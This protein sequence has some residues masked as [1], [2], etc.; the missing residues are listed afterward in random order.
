MNGG[1]LNEMVDKGED[2][3]KIVELEQ[4]TLYK[5]INETWI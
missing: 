5:L 1:W 4:L 3:L 2:A